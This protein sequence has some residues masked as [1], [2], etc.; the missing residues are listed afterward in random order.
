MFGPSRSKV[1]MFHRGSKT[2][3]KMTLTIMTLSISTLGIKILSI[4]TLGINI[5]SIA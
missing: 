2:I 3:N 1:S 4:A 5:L